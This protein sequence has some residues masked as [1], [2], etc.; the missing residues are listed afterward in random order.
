M[1]EGKVIKVQDVAF[2]TYVHSRQVLSA[3]RLIFPV[4]KRSSSTYTRTRSSSP[5][6]DPKRTV[7]LGPL[8]FSL[9]P[10]IAYP[11]LR[12]N[13]STALPIRYTLLRL[14]AQPF[15]LTLV[16]QYDIPGLKFAA[17][18]KIKEGLRQC[19]AV[20]ETFSRFASQYVPVV[21]DVAVI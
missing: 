5:P 2:V 10:Q 11:D 18:K 8:K 19:D 13:P 3:D 20:R 16:V 14:I 1:N 9:S 6:S 21:R 4:S 12:P 15:H 7:K 17:L